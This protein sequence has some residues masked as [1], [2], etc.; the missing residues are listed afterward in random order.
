MILL[1]N[2]FENGKLFDNQ[3]KTKYLNIYLKAF[4][5]VML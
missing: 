5:T 1:W 4:E 3:L 2:I